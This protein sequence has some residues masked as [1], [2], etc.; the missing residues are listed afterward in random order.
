MTDDCT[1]TAVTVTVD[2]FHNNKK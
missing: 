2:T 1:V